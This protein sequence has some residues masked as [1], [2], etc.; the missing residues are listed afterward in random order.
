MRKAAEVAGPH[1]SCF[2]KRNALSTS[3]NRELMMVMLCIWELSGFE[4]S[5]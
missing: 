4:G 5:R 2:K 1:N 3:R